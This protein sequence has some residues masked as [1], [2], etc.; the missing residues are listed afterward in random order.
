MIRLDIIWD[1]TPQTNL[2]K[3]TALLCL[4]LMSTALGLALLLQPGISL[5]RPAERGRLKMDELQSTMYNIASPLRPLWILSCPLWSR[6]ILLVHRCS[7]SW[8]QRYLSSPEQ[9][10]SGQRLWDFCCVGRLLLLFLCKFHPAF[11]LHGAGCLTGILTWILVKRDRQ[12][13][14]PRIR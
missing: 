14:Q 4:A 11:I 9:E 12:M 5:T 8:C 7:T 13:H 10:C 6:R 3:V 2:Q 1:S